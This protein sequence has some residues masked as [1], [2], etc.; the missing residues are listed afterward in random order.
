MKW[1]G[2]DMNMERAKH[3]KISKAFVYDESDFSRLGLNPNAVETWEDGMRTDGKKGTFEWWYFDV[4]LKNGSTLVIVFYTKNI[5][6][7][8]SDIQPFIT[9]HLTDVNGKEIYSKVILGDFESFQASVKHCDVKIG[10]NRFYGDLSEYHIIINESD[11]KAE[12]FLKNEVE[13]YRPGTGYAFFQHHKKEKY[14]AWMPAVPQGQVTGRIKYNGTELEIKGSGYH[15]HNW[16]NTMMTEL[17]HHWYWGRA[18]VGPYTLINSHMVAT[19]KYGGSN[20]NIFILFKDGKLIAE[21][22]RHVTCEF[23]D[24]Y[25]DDLTKKPVAKKIIYRYQSEDE[26]YRITYHKSKDISRNKF[27]NLMSGIKKQI[28]KLIGFDGAYLRFSG[29][30]TVEHFINQKRVAIESSSSAVWELM[31]FGHAKV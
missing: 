5:I 6:S 4:T 26:E 14:F 21:D 15:D 24:E 7:I 22:P 20:Q 10:G 29:S 17:L 25:V 30:V 12:L 18:E 3:S 1:Y 11:V 28:A 2:G 9:I 8:N 13:L 19:Q 16:G 27:V 23:E 31:Y